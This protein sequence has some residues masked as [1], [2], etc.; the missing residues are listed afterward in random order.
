M[1]S[2]NITTYSTEHIHCVLIW[3]TAAVSELRNPH[4]L[5]RY[6]D[7]T[8]N[9]CVTLTHGKS[10]GPR[11]QAGYAPLNAARCQLHYQQTLSHLTVKFNKDTSS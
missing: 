6:S 10:R 1:A 4:R 3:A 5:L 7:E 2:P 8:E 11:D 9:Q